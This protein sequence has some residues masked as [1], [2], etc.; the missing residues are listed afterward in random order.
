MEQAQPR[1]STRAGI[2]LRAE[3]Y[4]DFVESRPK[5]GFV[6]AHRASAIRATP[7]TSRPCGEWATSSPTSAA[8]WS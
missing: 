4:V 2:G 3:H 8:D 7:T 6:E 1:W 5:I